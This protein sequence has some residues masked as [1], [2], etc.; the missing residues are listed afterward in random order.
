MAARFFNK[1]SPLSMGTHDDDDAAHHRQRSVYVVAH[2]CNDLTSVESALANGANA[3]ECDVRSSDEGRSWC[4]D[5]DLCALWSTSFVAWLR[6]TAL[7]FNRYPDA[8]LLIVDIKTP[9]SNF[10][11]LLEM[12]DQQLPANVDVVLS[13]ATVVD[14]DRARASTPLWTPDTTLSTTG[15]RYFM[16]QID[17][18]RVGRALTRLRADQLRS[19][20]LSAGVCVVCPGEERVL[21]ATRAAIRV[22]DDPSLREATPGLRVG[23]WTYERPESIRRYLI[24]VGVDSIVVTQAAVPDACRI[25]RENAE[26]VRMAKRR[27]ALPHNASCV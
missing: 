11:E 18:D 27:L 3:I 21:E 4:V 24:D 7:A 25:V 1:Q 23:V 16:V 9:T 17:E 19:A 2:R 5:H 20:W 22:R 14:Y 12:I 15:S 6:A 13:V 10:I 26:F 8:C